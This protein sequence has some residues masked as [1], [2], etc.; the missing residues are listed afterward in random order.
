MEPEARRQSAQRSIPERRGKGLRGRVMLYWI[1]LQKQCPSIVL[2][3]MML[4]Q[5]NTGT[6]RSSWVRGHRDSQLARN[7]HLKF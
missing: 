4:G 5:W 6:C 3:A 1:V 2:V 7:N